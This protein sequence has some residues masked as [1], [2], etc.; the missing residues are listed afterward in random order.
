MAWLGCLADK[1]RGQ[2]C[3][4]QP[5]PGPLLWPEAVGTGNNLTLPVALALQSA[6][7]IGVVP[8]PASRP[9]RGLVIIIFTGHPG[10]ICV[11]GPKRPNPALS[12]LPP[13]AS[14][15]RQ[16]PAQPVWSGMTRPQGGSSS[17]RLPGGRVACVTQG[18]WE[19]RVAA[20]LSSVWKG[21]GCGAGLGRC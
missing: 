6:E 13:E 11:S 21:C 14:Q 1:S 10:S 8:G 20:L 9:T 12:P 18:R 17:R 19:P 15:C 5:P 4:T 7:L 2:Q 3:I 16:G